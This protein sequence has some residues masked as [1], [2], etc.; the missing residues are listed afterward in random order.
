M[1]SWQVRKHGEPRDALQIV[2][3]AAPVPASGMLRVR[4]AASG[5]GLPDLLMCRGSYPLTPPLPF[6]PGQEL[7]GVVTAVGENSETRLGARVMAVSGFMLGRGGFAEEA[8]ALDEF[9]LPVPES[10]SDAEAAGFL[11]PYHTAYVALVTR[12]EL[13]AGE[14]LLVLGA[15]GGSGSAALQLGRALGARVLATAGGSEKLEF[16]R[17]LGAELV[18]DYRARDIAEAALEATEGRGADVIYDAVGGDA[19]TA[20]TRCIARG[21]RLL[22]VGFASG[23]WGTPSV[24]HMALRNYSVVGVMTGSYG[25]A[26]NHAAH[27]ALLSHQR[28]GEIHVPIHRTLAFDDLAEGLE[29]LARGRVMGKMVLAV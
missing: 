26:F 8:L 24:A 19:F 7:V 5:L 6:T 13:R 4:V 9:A 22:A 27:Q 11:I 29:E 17:R 12:G 10:M 21:G 2:E 20:A 25:R 3:A 16:C 14:T 1:R 23:Q 18:I 28:R 15:A